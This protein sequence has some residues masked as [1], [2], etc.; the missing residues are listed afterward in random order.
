MKHCA[1]NKAMPVSGWL[2]RHCPLQLKS[3]GTHDTRLHHI[4]IEPS[5]PHTFESRRK[6]TAALRS[7]LLLLLGLRCCN[8]F[9][10]IFVTQY[11]S[12]VGTTVCWSIRK[13]IP[14]EARLWS[15]ESDCHREELAYRN[16][17]CIL[18][19]QVSVA[20]LHDLLLQRLRP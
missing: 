13:I 3:C 10:M 17:K 11:G 4:V 15:C 5:N 19:D 6:C 18:T 2:M 20:A 7:S 16:S 1:I 8:Q 9:K 14:A 12:V